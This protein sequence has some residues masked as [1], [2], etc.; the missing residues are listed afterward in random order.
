MEKQYYPFITP[1]LGTTAVLFCFTAA[2]DGIL[3]DGVLQEAFKPE[4]LLTEVLVGAF[5]GLVVSQIE[6]EY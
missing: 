4:T 3:G 2:F 6:D 5:V 1:F